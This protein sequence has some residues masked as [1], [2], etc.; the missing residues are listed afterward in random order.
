MGVEEIEATIARLVAEER[1][2]NEQRSG[3]H[4]VIDALE[5]ELI[6]RYKAGVASADDLLGGG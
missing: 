6:D 2:L 4:H 5:A 3:V 1:S